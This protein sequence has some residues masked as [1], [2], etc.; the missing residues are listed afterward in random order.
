MV[1][2]PMAMNQ[3]CYGVIGKNN[4]SD[5]YIYFQLKMQSK[6]FNKWD[7]AQFSTQ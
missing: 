7:T 1:A 6:P 5:E 3:S 2:V 4:I